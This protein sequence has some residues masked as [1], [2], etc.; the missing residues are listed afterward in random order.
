[1]SEVGTAVAERP[2]E[3]VAAPLPAQPVSEAGTLLNIIERAAFDPNVS[4][5]KITSLV[6]LSRSVK[7]DEAKAAYTKA[8]LKLK[9]ALPIIERNGTIKIY[10]KNAEQ[11]DAN[12]IQST[13]YARWEDIDTAIT[14]ILNSHGFALTF[15]TGTM[16]DGR[17][18]VTA[19]L[20][21][22]A[23]HSEES[24]MA[25]PLDTSGSKNNVQAA[26]SST[27]YGKRYTASALLNLRTKGEDDD[28]TEGGNPGKLTQDQL[29][30][31]RNLI[32]RFDADIEKF[33][34]YMGVPSLAD[35]LV[36]DYEKA[37]RALNMKATQQ[38]KK[39]GA[40]S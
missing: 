8:M 35:I 27:S 29:T 30:T 14:P 2:A 20:S 28:G 19:I 40:K 38:G 39:S 32:D 21:H 11:I 31:I 7:A 37:I 6:N 26:G 13:P 18:T 22:E 33:C 3:Q 24:V 9:L 5:E 15:R 1:M 34:E 10:K 12:L 4:A 36:T 23:G 16:E 25:L 17:V